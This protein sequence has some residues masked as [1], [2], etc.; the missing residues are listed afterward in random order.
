MP[1]NK[2]GKHHLNT[3]KAMASDKMPP[4][5]AK[6]AMPAKPGA[7]AGGVGDHMPGGVNE[8]DIDGDST[9]TIITHGSDGSHMVDHADGEQ[10]G[11]HGDIEE[12]LDHIRMKHGMQK[13]PGEPRHGM[14][15]H[16]HAL[17]GI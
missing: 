9:R 15:M 17:Q 5:P 10:T 14:P 1:F 7:P 2:S 12:A 13:E 11:P 3:Q 4:R 6:A 8:G 16:E